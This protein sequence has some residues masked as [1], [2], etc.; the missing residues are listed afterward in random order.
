MR[1]REEDLT[2]QEVDHEI[3]VLD[4]RASSY[5]KLNGSAAVLWKHL[6]AGANPDELATS[7]TDIFEVDGPT[8]RRDVDAFLLKLKRGDLLVEE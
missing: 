1:L 6:Q 7:L 4:L 3:V 5:L 2:W 8:A